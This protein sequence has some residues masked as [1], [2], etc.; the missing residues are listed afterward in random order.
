MDL[1]EERNLWRQQMEEGNFTEPH[2]LYEEYLKN[3]NSNL[4]RCSRQLEKIFEYINYLE[5]L[6]GSAKY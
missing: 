1:I 2:P 4:W 6:V 5:C 3:R